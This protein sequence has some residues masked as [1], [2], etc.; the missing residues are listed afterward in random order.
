MASKDL[1]GEFPKPV[2][3]RGANKVII[4]HLLNQ[5]QLV[6]GEKLVRS[7]TGEQLSGFIVIKLGEIWEL[8]KST[9]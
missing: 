3:L 4:D 2:K 9:L 7:S 1:F 6:E 8:R 5:K